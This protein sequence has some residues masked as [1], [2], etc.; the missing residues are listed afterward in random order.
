MLEKRS[1]CGIHMQ[2]KGKEGEYHMQVKGKGENH[3]T[4]SFGWDDAGK[5]AM[6]Y[7][8]KEIKRGQIL[9]DFCM[10]QTREFGPYAIANRNWGL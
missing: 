6:E 7:K 4:I 9:E 10:S 5:W 2:V 1:I 3:K 8:I